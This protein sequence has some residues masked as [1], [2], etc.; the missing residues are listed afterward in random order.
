MPQRQL[1]LS[2]SGFKGGLNTEASSLTILPSEFASGTFNIDLKSNGTVSPRRGVDFL[3]ESTTGSFLHTVRANTI[4]LEV[5][6]ESPN[7]I[8]VRFKSPSGILVSRVIIFINNEFR[9]YND[10]LDTLKDFDAP[11][12]TIALAGNVGSNQKSYNMVFKA[13]DNR[14][15]FTGRHLQPGYLKVD[16]DNITLVTG[17]LDGYVRKTN[18]TSVGT[19]VTKVFATGTLL[20]EALQNHVGAANTEPGTGADW[21]RYWQRLDGPLPTSGTSVWAIGVQ[22]F[23]AFENKFDSTEVMDNTTL[24]PTAM[25]FF[26]GRLWLGIDNEVLFSQVIRDEDDPDNDVNRFHQFADPFDANDSFIVDDD[27]GTIQLQGAGTIIQFLA[28]GRS[29]YIGTSTGVRQISSPDGVF[30]AGNFSNQKVIT[31]PISSP[32]AMVEVDQRVMVFGNTSIWLSPVP[33]EFAQV[34]IDITNFVSI[35]EVKRPIGDTDRVSGIQ[36]LYNSIPAQNRAS[37]KTV[38]FPDTKSV[39]YFFNEILTQ[40]DLDHNNLEQP[41]YYTS[42]FKFNVTN[43]EFTLHR[44]LDGGKDGKPYIS[45][46]FIAPSIQVRNDD[47]VIGTDKVVIGTD[48]VVIPTSDKINELL[49]LVLQRVEPVG[50]TWELFTENWEDIDD[51]WEALTG[52]GTAIVNATFGRMETDEIVDWNMDSTYTNDY[53]AKL[54]GGI[55]TGGDMRVKASPNYVYVVFQRIDNGGCFLTLSTQ[56]AQEGASKYGTPRQVYLPDRFGMDSTEY[57]KVWRKHRVRGRGNVFQYIFEKEALKDF[58]LE[59]FSEQVGV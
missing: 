30:K 8:H 50:N 25:E 29:L 55:Q 34:N 42:Y 56:W 32:S 18:N 16:T 57:E 28:Q 26:A 6:H 33:S 14:V 7:A 5:N 39:Y 40:F 1:N 9:I 22:Y 37:A 36:S 47:M 20:Y 35:S 38:Y 44:M 27:G 45:A 19:R 46:P 4:D 12:Q 43:E 13:T 3:G 31:D 23:S 2:I 53:S 52:T 59:G 11:L 54:V 24:R 17:F 58:I 10:V 49:V 15:Y 48:Q 21:D 41:G 51:S